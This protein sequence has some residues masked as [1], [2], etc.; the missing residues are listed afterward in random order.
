ML[1]NMWFLK[2]KL[3]KPNATIKLSPMTTKE[4]CLKKRINQR[5]NYHHMNS[6]DR[7]G[8]F[9]SRPKGTHFQVLDL[10]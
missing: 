7:K 8:K 10:Q 6:N 5:T 3:I 1:S 9:D 2:R 4:L